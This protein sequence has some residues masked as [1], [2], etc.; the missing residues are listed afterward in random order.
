LH[1]IALEVVIPFAVGPAEQVIDAGEYAVS[2][3]FFEK[4]ILNSP[5]ECPELHWELDEQ[6]QPTQDI[7]DGRRPAICSVGLLSTSSWTAGT[8]TEDRLC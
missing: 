4:P 1:C 6:G 5:Y 7:K 3:R 2:D 8:K